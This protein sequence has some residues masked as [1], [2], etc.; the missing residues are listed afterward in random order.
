MAAASARLRAS[1]PVALPA[2][3]FYVRVCHEA[4][5]RRAIEAQAALEAPASR[6]SIGVCRPVCRKRFERDLRIDRLRNLQPGHTPMAKAKTKEPKKPK[7]PMHVLDPGLSAFVTAYD[8]RQAV[9]LCGAAIWFTEK[10]SGFQVTRRHAVVTLTMALKPGKEWQPIGRSLDNYRPC[11]ACR[12]LALLSPADRV[13]AI[14][15]R[16]IDKRSKSEADKIARADAK[17]ERDDVL[18]IEI[19]AAQVDALVCL[20]KLERDEVYLRRCKRYVSITIDPT[21]RGGLATKCNLEKHHV[22]K[23][24]AKLPNERMLVDIDEVLSVAIKAQ[25]HASGHPDRGDRLYVMRAGVR[26][27]NCDWEGHRGNNSKGLCCDKPDI[28]DDQPLNKKD[29]ICRFCDHIIA[30]DYKLGTDYSNTTPVKAHCIPCALK[31]LG[32][33]ETTAQDDAPPL[34]NVLPATSF[35]LELDS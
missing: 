15:K 26:C 9:G 25:K 18:T 8:N 27:W 30:R 19:D 28:R 1:A 10:P 14:A 5:A 32:K 2:T 23:C 33:V 29:L 13:L 17:Q 16:G 3:E 35:V 31:Y 21:V 11:Y 12:K 6:G 4:A 24:R 20:D 34:T 7:K 22:D